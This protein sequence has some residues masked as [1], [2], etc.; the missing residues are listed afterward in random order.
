MAAGALLPVSLNKMDSQG[1]FL[2]FCLCTATGFFGGVI[3]EPFSFIRLLCRCHADKNKIIGM[4]ID[5]LFCLI[6]A[7]LYI[8]LAYKCHFLAFRAY[9]CLGYAL[10]FIIYLKILH[11]IVA[12]FE[13]VC[14]NMIAQ[15][16]K[17]IKKQEKTLKKEVNI[18]I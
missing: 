16:A 8:S 5:L 9:M 6:F 2:V 10:G 15:K 14:Y 11:R 1:Q 7:L 12:F 18:N 17:K 13:K 3:Y 4:I